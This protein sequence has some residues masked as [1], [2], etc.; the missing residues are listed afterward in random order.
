[1]LPVVVGVAAGVAAEEVVVA[2]AG[3]AGVAFSGVVAGSFFVPDVESEGGFILS[4]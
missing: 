3:E 4:E 2:G 1:M